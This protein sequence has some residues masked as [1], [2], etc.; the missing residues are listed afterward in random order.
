MTQDQNKGIATIEYNYLNLPERVT[1]TDG[2]YIKY[3]YDAA[4]VKLA[5]EVYDATN[6]LIKRTDYIGEFIYETEGVEPALTSNEGN[7]SGEISTFYASISDVEI[8]GEDYLKVDSDLDVSTPSITVATIPVIEG[9]VYEFRLKGYHDGINTPYLR[10]RTDLGFLV[11]LGSGN[12]TIEK[13][14][15]NDKWYEARFTVPSGATSLIVGAGWH[16]QHDGAD[17]DDVMYIDKYVLNKIKESELSFIQHEEG[18]VVPDDINGWEYQYNL[19]DHLGNTRVTFT[20]Q[21]NTVEFNL[22]YEPDATVDVN[23]ETVVNDT[24]LLTDTDKDNII[25][26]NV[27][28]HTDAHPSATYQHAYVLNGNASSRAGSVVQFNVGAGD[29][30][31]SKV[32]VKLFN[33]TSN[34]VVDPVAIGGILTGILTSGAAPVPEG[35]TGSINSGYN[36]TG[37]LFGTDGFDY[38]DTQPMVFLNMLF[39]PADGFEAVTDAHFKYVQVT[40]ANNVWEEMALPEFEAEEPGTVMIYVSNEG[41]VQLEAYFDDMNVVVDEHPVIQQDDYYPFGLTFN[42]GYQRV[43]AKENHFKYNGKEEITDLDVNWYD[44]GARMYMADIGRWGVVDNYSELYFGTSTYVYALN[45]PTNA[46]DPDGNLVIFINGN[47]FGDGATGYEGW[48]IGTDSY[49][50]KGSSSYWRRGTMHF[51]HAVMSRL[52][53][54]NAIYR[55]GGIG[56]FFGFSTDNPLGVLYASGRRFSGYHQ[57]K[58]DAKQII[59]NLKRDQSTGEIIESIKIITHSMGG[60][61]GKG[62]LR[63]LKEYIKTLPP[64]QQ[65]QIRITLVA[66]FDPF[67]AGSLLADPEIFTQQFVHKNGD[68]REDS[69]GLGWLANQKQEGV[70]EYYESNSEAAHSIFSFF[71]NITDLQEGTYEYNEETNSWDCTSCND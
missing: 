45:Q 44:Y 48:R 3:I 28:D 31:N 12:T 24:D 6:T 40:D 61:Y 60:A 16:N 26:N 54:T 17:F 13:G 23:G 11:P 35:V 25:L 21:P 39:I 8:D 70:D 41:G 10:I 66:D 63:A 38:D 7:V 65:R 19:K 58:R 50:W 56:G 14:V 1:K 52:R 4:G 49:N 53:D 62:Y 18:R 46:I 29:V 68:G 2:Q 5:Q 27:F 43:T 51:D 34:Q 64:E 59:A 32:Q 37:G 15:A 57:G 36:P 55:D 67:Q 42:N 69:D 33:I 30:V 9:E 22:F 47:H 71:D 20:T